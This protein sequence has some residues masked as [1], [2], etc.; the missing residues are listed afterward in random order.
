MKTK[1]DT[2]KLR[3]IVWNLLVLITLVLGL[4]V[5]PARAAPTTIVGGILTS[6]TTWTAEGSPYQVNSTLTVAK[7]VT[8]TIE[9]G[10]T[11]ENDSSGGSPSYQFLVEGRLLANG[12]AAE[13]ISF[14]PGANGWSGIIIAGTAEETNTGSV[15][16]YAILDGGGFGGS[17]VAANLDLRY[18]EVTVRHCQFNNSPGDGVLGNDDSAR[19]VAH[20]SDSSFTHNAGYAVFFQDAS[21]NPV[22]SNLTASGNGWGEPLPYGGDMVAIEGVHP[23]S[24]M[25]VWENMGLPYLDIAQLSV[26]PGSTLTIE[27]GVQVLLAAGND[28]LDI[29]GR[30]IATGTATQP[31]RFDAVDPAEGWSGLR[32]LGSEAQPSQGNILNQVILTG[33]GVE[34][35]CGLRLE[36]GDAT[37]TNSQFSANGGDGVCLETGASL[38]MTDTQIT[39]NADYAIDI[40]DA[41]TQFNFSGLTASGNLS[42]TIGVIG[43]N[44]IQGVHTWPAGGINTYEIYG[45]VT[46]S[47][48]GVLNIDPGVTVSFA[49]GYD[50][51]IYGALNANGSATQPVRFTGW[52][53]APGFWAGLDFWG[54]PQQ[55]AQGRFAYTT[56]EYG[57]YGGAALVGLTDADVTFD[58]CTLQNSTSDAIRIYPGAAGQSLAARLAA[59]PVSPTAMQI[60][61]SKLAAL[62]G[63]AIDNRAS[64]PVQASYNWWGA[65]SGPTASDNPNGSG[66]GLNGAVLFFPYMLSPNGSFIYLPI[67]VH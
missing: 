10:V 58:H 27:A 4:A 22:L 40:F 65:A 44:P 19:G 50:L 13:P 45:G 16:E 36:Y 41:N 21:V 53:P 64:Q 54:T 56:L 1:T 48:S 55:P 2:L 29:Q 63:Y 17:G 39:H 33:G 5:Q 42:D 66:S 8:L 49:Y 24:G 47:A 20:I 59:A 34:H 51:A 6:D 52:Q 57:G 35:G 28:A 9:A 67:L 38:V 18:A 31:V 37:I 3:P 62:G 46:I 12:T 30:I 26:A 60:H 32:I 14:K 15:L 11:V 25:H 43:Q 23:M 7:G 61:W